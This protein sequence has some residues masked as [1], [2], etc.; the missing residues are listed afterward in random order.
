M[1]K[2]KNTE[3]NEKVFLLERIPYQFNE[4]PFW[5][6]GTVG[7]LMYIEGSVLN[8]VYD[9][10]LLWE[11]RDASGGQLKAPFSELLKQRQEYSEQWKLNMDAKDLVAPLFPLEVGPCSTRL[12][13]LTLKIHLH[14]DI[15]DFKAEMNLEQ[16]VANISLKCSDGSAASGRVYIHSCKNILEISFSGEAAKK[17]QPWMS[18]WDYSIPS[19]EVL[20]KWGYPGAVENSEGLFKHMLQYFG[21]NQAAVMTLHTEE[22]EGQRIFLSALHVGDVEKIDEL[23]GCN[24]MLVQKHIAERENSLAE[25]FSS[26]EEYWEK[27]EIHIPDERLQQ[28]SELEMYKLFCNA[29]KYSTPVTL[30]GIW[31]YDRV[32]PPWLGDLHNDL[33]V[34]A[35]YWAAF[36]TGHVDLVYP[37]IKYYSEAIPHFHYRAKLFTGIDNA[38]HVPTLMNLKGHGAG[39]EWCFWNTLIG[40]ELYAAVDFCWY[41]EFTQD[42]KILGE[43]VYPYLEGV[44]NLYK[45]IANEGEDGFLH[46][47][48]TQSPEIFEGEKMLLGEDS[49]FIVSSIRYVL[50]NLINYSQILGYNTEKNKWESLLNSFAE[51]QVSENGYQIMRGKELTYSHR[52]FSH[53][54]PLFPLGV[55]NRCRTEDDKLM[56]LCLDNVRKFGFI[57]YA[58]FS[59]PYLAIL[60]ARCGRGNMARMLLE[61]YC[62]CFRSR[63][64][65]TVN[66][67][68]YHTGI[69][70]D[71]GDSAGGPPESFTLETGLIV[72]AAVVEM[73]VH[74]VEA[75]IFVLPAIPDDWKWCRGKGLTLEG[76]HA[77]DVRMEEYR[78]NE[79]VI[80]PGMNETITVVCERAWGKYVLLN[81]N[82]TK[83]VTFKKGM[84]LILDLVKGVEV[85]IFTLGP[86]Q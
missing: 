77:V 69:L 71:S 17:M 85:R 39:A 80:R 66:G 49:T 68:A 26:W 41:Y 14:A 57:G 18:G 6:N 11:T 72:P 83:E 52:H 56:Q 10:V 44:V 51:E 28:A 23:K 61:V 54:F 46:I 25:H 37:Y 53:L 33:N 21:D 35:C 32:L 84:H 75:T 36:K 50:K 64:G 13:G 8:F 38:I 29:R 27:F 79:L 47:P 58:A 19:L 12:P 62:M 81:E 7:S 45:G 5:G 59:F 63:N 86:Y 34:Q 82:G 65:F 31:N 43:I 76:A 15:T 40:P 48:M 73:M 24:S 30:Q 67:D 16:A 2:E 20:Q 3:K 70:A 60:A 74:R 42:K 1:L 4:G 78:L 9:H 55:L 22:S